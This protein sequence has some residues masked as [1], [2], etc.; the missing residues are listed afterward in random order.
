MAVELAATVVTDLA[1]A[2]ALRMMDCR[3]HLRLLVMAKVAAYH[4]P[5]IRPRPFS[6]CV[7]QRWS[8]RQGQG[9]ERDGQQRR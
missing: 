6:H 5:H 7:L 9:G 1:A 2:A 4:P 8:G 3:Q